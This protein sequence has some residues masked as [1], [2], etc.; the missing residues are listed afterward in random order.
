[1]DRINNRIRNRVDLRIRNRIDRFYNPQ[2]DAAS[3]FDTAN[4]RSRINSD[5]RGR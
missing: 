3:S 4:N 1:M 5:G 2:G